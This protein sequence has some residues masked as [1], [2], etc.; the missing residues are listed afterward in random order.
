MLAVN[1]P[2]EEIRDQIAGISAGARLGDNIVARLNAPGLYYSASRLLENLDEL[3]AIQR[4]D[5]Q[6]A[7]AY[8]AK[9]CTLRPVMQMVATTNLKVEVQSVH[10]MRQARRVGISGERFVWNSPRKKS[11]DMEVA[12]SEGATVILDSPSE[13]ED[14]IEF[15][16]GRSATISTQIGIRVMLSGDGYFSTG[17]GKLGMPI[18]DAVAVVRRLQVKGIAPGILHCHALARV[19]DLA[20]YKTF[21]NAVTNIVR[22]VRGA[23]G[24]I[25]STVD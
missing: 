11:G 15:A 3:I 6:I 9:A 25:F 23:T 2:V 21:L 13:A 24:H 4:H 5:P 19:E 22:E 14:V 7:F 17:A 16:G 18:G 8:A 10:E 1:P 20:V 12:L